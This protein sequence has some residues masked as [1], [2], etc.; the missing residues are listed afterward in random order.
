MKRKSFKSHIKK[1]LY[2]KIPIFSG[3][4]PYFGTNVYFPNNSLIFQMA[5]EQGIYEKENLKFILSLVHPETMY[6]DVGANIGLMSI[7]VLQKYESCQVVSFEPSP[8]T[9]S[10]LV[11]TCENSQY[12]NRWHVIGKG[13]GSEPGIL[14]FYIATPAMGA[15]D[16]LQDT[17]RANTNEKISINVTTIDTEWQTLGSPKVSLIKIDIEGAELDALMGAIQCIDKCRPYLLL[18]W[19]TTNLKAYGYSIDRILS[20]AKSIGYRLY[21]LPALVEIHEVTQLQLHMLLTESFLLAP[22]SVSE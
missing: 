14:D 2:G 22:S 3:S 13:A 1:I 12:A 9:L 8:N 5:C 17:K 7:P 18:E 10:Y 19:N 4:F 11:R 15:F 6:F 20:F 21:S 16:G